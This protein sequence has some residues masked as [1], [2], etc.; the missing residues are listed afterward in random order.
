[1][2]TLD[3]RVDDYIANAAEFARPILIELRKRVHAACPAVTETIKWRM[4]SFEHHGLL[5]GMAAFKAHLTFGFWKDALLREVADL[6]GT[7]EK[8]GCMK[9][10][11]D[12]PP[13]AAFAKVLKR[14]VE[15]NETGVA[16]PRATAKTKRPVVLHAEFERALKA[17]KKAKAVFDAF[18]PSCKHEYAEW[19]GEAKKDATRA[20]RIEQA[21][22]WI[23]SGKKRNWK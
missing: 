14:A 15:L 8:V 5:G 7:V 2:P 1:M 19:I 11:A 10:L 13:K 20:R 18:A 12:L 3:P 16:T 21:I 22:E 17:N 23:A 4:P 6:A 9:T